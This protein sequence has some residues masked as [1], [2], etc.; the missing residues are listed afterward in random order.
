MGEIMQPWRLATFVLLQARLILYVSAD[1]CTKYPPPVQRNNDVP[2]LLLTWDVQMPKEGL[3]NNSRLAMN[4][5]L[6]KV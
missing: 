3:F 2:P 1:Y 6:L 5:H 4:P